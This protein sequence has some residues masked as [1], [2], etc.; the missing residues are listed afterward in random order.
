MYIQHEDDG[1]AGR[2][3]ITE[4]S[5][6]LAEMDYSRRGPEHIVIL[7]TEVAKSLEGKGVG[8]ELVAAG[9]AYAREHGIKIIPVCAFAKAVMER[10]P[11]YA[12][13][14]G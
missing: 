12:D 4:G 14:I 8:K 5:K 3:F 11:E 10:T 2:F 1:K 7:H 6:S 13:V 9:V